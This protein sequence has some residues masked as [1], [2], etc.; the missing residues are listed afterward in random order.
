MT[1]PSCESGRR[2]G[3]DDDLPSRVPVH[4]VT[5]PFTRWPS[6]RN[7]ALGKVGLSHKE[8]PSMVIARA[9]CLVVLGTIAAAAAPAVAGK[10]HV[11]KAVPEDVQ[12]G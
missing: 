4:S 12:W 7:R 6:H 2:V 1:S 11:L 9:R 8:R 10:D 5:E 3:F